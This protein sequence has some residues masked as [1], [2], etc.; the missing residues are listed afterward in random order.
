[1]NNFKPGRTLPY[2]APE[3]DEKV[4]QEKLDIFSFGM[5]M[6]EY[7]FEEL[8]VDYMKNNLEELA[9]QY[10]ERKYQIR[11]MEEYVKI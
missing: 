2:A 11:L 4:Y 6:S 7:I 3:L 9:R 5:M 10:Q 8:P 1:M